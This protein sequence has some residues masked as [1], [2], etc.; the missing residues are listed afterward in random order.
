MWI[1]A[2]KT[3]VDRQPN[4]EDRCG[5]WVEHSKGQTTNQYVKDQ[6][7]EL[8]D[9]QGVEKDRLC[10]GGSRPERA[11]RKVISSTRQEGSNDGNQCEVNGND[12][13]IRCGRQ[14]DAK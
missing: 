13:V 6:M 8:I 9:C 10:K 5:N 2:R 7:V 4:E 1:W 3:K 14:F 12:E 11:V